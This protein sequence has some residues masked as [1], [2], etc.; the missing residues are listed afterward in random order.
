MNLFKL[1]QISFR[2]YLK[3]FPEY[4]LKVG[5]QPIIDKFIEGTSREP[6][7]QELKKYI[8]LIVMPT[9][10]IKLRFKQEKSL[11]RLIKKNNERRETK[12]YQSPNELYVS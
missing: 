10:D 5:R 9:S 1:N 4:K 6:T 2:N 12:R 11:L 3:Q 7:E 8:E